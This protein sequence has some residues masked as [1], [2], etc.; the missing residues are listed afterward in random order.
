MSKNELKDIIEVTNNLRHRYILSS[1]LCAGS[2]CNEL[3]TQS[4]INIIKHKN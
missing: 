4:T 3:L 2:R 1:D